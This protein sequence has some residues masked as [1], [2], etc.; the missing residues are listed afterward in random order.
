MLEYD[1]SIKISIIDS[2]NKEDNNERIGIYLSC[3]ISSPGY[4]YY[5]IKK[6]IES[7]NLEFD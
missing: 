2:L 6:F 5:Y 7:F 3:F 4:D 1:F